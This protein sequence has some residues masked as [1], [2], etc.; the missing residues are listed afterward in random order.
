MDAEGNT[1]AIVLAA[2]EGS[3]LRSL[4]TTALGVAIPKQFCSL[5]GGG[6]AANCHGKI[7]CSTPASQFPVRGAYR[8]GIGRWECGVQKQVS[9]RAAGGRECLFAGMKIVEVLPYPWCQIVGHQKRAIHGS[10]CGE[11]W[12]H[13][14]SG[15]RQCSCELRQACILPTDPAD[16]RGL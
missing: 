3:R 13:P 1:W 10:G 7:C 14:D 8:F 12:R 4:T 15:A 6:A 2:G 9:G 16:I 5:K 11:I